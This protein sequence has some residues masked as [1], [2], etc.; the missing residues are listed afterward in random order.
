MH[1]DGPLGVG[2]AG[3]H[4]LS[5]T[6]YAGETTQLTNTLRTNRPRALLD[7]PCIVVIPMRT[8]TR[9]SGAARFALD[10]EPAVCNVA[11]MRRLHFLFCAAMG[12][13]SLATGMPA[14]K[15]N[16]ITPPTLA[17]GRVE[18][19][20][21]D[22]KGFVARVHGTAHNPNAVPLPVR[23]VQAEVS[24][25]GQDAAG[26]QSA[27]MSTLAPGAD[28]PVAFDVTV[29]WPQ[30]SLLASRAGGVD[31]VPYTVTGTAWV[32]TEG[33]EF[34]FPFTQSGSVRKAEIV[35]AALKFVPLDIDR[36]R[37]QMGDRKP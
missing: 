18:P 3:N 13:L 11:R 6:T 17:V 35:V 8:I 25:N 21:T 32:G 24:V 31:P 7:L 34:P 33:A 29:P 28:T 2:R 9:R 1:T 19:V 22:A 37:R 27:S 14:C 12:A 26:V 5:F 30:L 16:P 36:L 15:A 23:R 20:L 4:R 10:T